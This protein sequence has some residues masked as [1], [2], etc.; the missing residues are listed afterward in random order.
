MLCCSATFASVDL[1]RVGRAAQ[2]PGQLGALREPG[3]AERVALGDQ[4]AGRVDDRAVAAVGRR[5]A[6]DEL[7]AVALL[8]EARAP[9]R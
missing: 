5:L 3:R 1:A 8:G 9:R 7:V 2:L 4:P 6:V